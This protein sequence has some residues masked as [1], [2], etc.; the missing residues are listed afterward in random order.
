M[1]EVHYVKK[2]QKDNA[3]VKKGEP[4]YWWSFRFGGK[5]RSKTPPR[6]SQLTQSGYLSAC[7]A[8]QEEIDD[9]DLSDPLTVAEEL[10]SAADAIREIGQEQQEKY[11]NMPTG[12]QEGDT[13]QL[14]Q[15]RADACEE[16]ASELD[17]AA[18]WVRDGADVQETISGLSWNF[19]V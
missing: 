16:V 11:D 17:D 6:P 13:G 8:L 4:Y 2:A 7:L 9:L 15:D 14:L 3:V 5:H 19:D 12:L 18:N 1:T 10:E